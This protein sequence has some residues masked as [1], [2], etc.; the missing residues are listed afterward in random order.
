ML[1]ETR[2]QAAKSNLGSSVS[3]IIAGGRKS[4]LEGNTLLGWLFLA[5]GVSGKEKE[6]IAVGDR[7]EIFILGSALSAN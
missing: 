4:Y 3:V 5:C 1:L 7:T 6:G 2:I